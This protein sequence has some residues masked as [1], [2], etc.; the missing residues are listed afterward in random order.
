MTACHQRPS[1]G[2]CLVTAA[3]SGEMPLSISPLSTLQSLSRLGL[4]LVSVC[5]KADAAIV[6]MWCVCVQV[7]VVC[8]CRCVCSYVYSLVHFGMSVCLYVCLETGVFVANFIDISQ[9]VH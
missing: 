4:Q 6:C 3:I 5:F 9:F 1:C 2:S 7:H 8:V